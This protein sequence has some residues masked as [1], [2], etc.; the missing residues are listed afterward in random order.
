MTSDAFNAQPADRAFEN[1]L[2]PKRF[3]DFPGQDRIRENLRIYIEAAKRRGEPLDHVLFSGP[4]GL[5]KTTLAGIVASEL[6][7]ESHTSSGPALERPADLAGLLTSL[8]EGHILFVDEV[9]RL[10]TVV[11]EYL[12]SAMEDWAI[13]IV[14]DSGLYAKSIHLTIPRFTLI[15]AT[16]REGLLTAPFRARFGIT[17]RLDY[18]AP[19]ELRTILRRSA[20]IL[21]VALSEDGSLELARRSRGTPRIANRFLARARDVAEVKGSGVIDHSAARETLRMLGIG[22]NGLADMDRRILQTLAQHD[23][24]PVGL[25]TIAVTVGESEDTLENVHEPYLLREGYIA[26]TPAGRKLAPAGW[27][28]VGGKNAGPGTLFPAG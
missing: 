2:R 17:E 8:G 23:G 14:M 13:D 12:Y 25:K 3:E 20:G 16:T 28:V 9:H 4:P 24:G 5:G 19:T 18:Y 22:E 1:R 15:G 27:D 26:K 10:P 6:G 11:E 21:G 7:V